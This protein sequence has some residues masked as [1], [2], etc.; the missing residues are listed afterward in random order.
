MNVCH[1][2]ESL[3]RNLSEAASVSPMHP[4][5]ITK[6]IS[7]ASE[8]DIDAV[9]HKGKLLIHAVSEH[10]ENAGVHSGDATLILPPRD[11]DVKTM[12]R[13]KEIAQK[14]AKAF[15]I[16]G[17]FNMQ[18]IKKDVPGEQ[19][20]LKVIECN[21]RAS[22]SFPF[23]SKVLGTNFIEV[24][25]HA[26][27]DHEVPKPVDVMAIK[28]DYQAVKV[29]QFSWTRLAGADPFLGVEMASTGEVACF[30][31]DKYEAYWSAIQSTQNFR[32]PKPGSG[33]L[34]GKDQ[35]TNEDDFYSVA[36]MLYKDLGHPIF[37]SSQKVTDDLAK[38]NIKATTLK[39]PE[40]NKRALQQTFQNNHIDFVF[41]L[42]SLRAS[43]TND[44]NY[45]ARRSAVDFGIP[46]VNDSKCARLFVESF[47][48]KRQELGSLSAGEYPGEVKSWSEFIGGRYC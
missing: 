37:T 1:N 42:A 24:A 5:V 10:V 25:T 36:Q 6:F 47:K 33:I 45:L 41:N 3:H 44:E 40:Q 12:E 48:R 43:D 15:E 35:Y 16:T 28:K 38:R 8:I 46:L 17:P 7:S 13:L 30:G 22:R 27:C 20:Q 18:I 32:I 23:V 34:I 14:V 19:P 29:P 21:L 4:V 9:A 31:K 39:L 26:L 11:I 2:R